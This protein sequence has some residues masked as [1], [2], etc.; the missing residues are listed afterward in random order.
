VT[1]TVWGAGAVGLVLGGR[2][3]RA[4]EDVFFVCRR[5]ESAEAIRAAGVRIEDLAS[6]ESFVVGAQAQPAERVRPEQLAGG[7]VLLCTRGPELEEA[8][9]AIQR[10]GYTGPVA[11]VTNGIDPEAAAAARFETVAG[12]VY[13]Q[14]CT[15]VAA[16]SAV[17]V[18]A[19]RV[20]VGAYPDGAAD[21]PVLDLAAQFARAGYDVGVSSRLSADRWLKLCVNLMSGPNALIRREDHTDP[22]FV[23]IKVRLLEEAR[24][25]LE[26]AGLH[27]CSCDERDRSLDEEIAFQR[28]AL[29][30]GNSARTLPL[31]NQVWSALR[32]G[33]TLEAD[34]YH[35]TILRLAA[36]YGLRAPMNE[37]VLEV[38]LQ[39]VEDRGGPERESATG[40]L[41]G[42]E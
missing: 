4:G 27:A 8:C 7:P 10:A 28:D 40:L 26:A 15:R 31:Y 37:R 16:H 23:A 1:T 30:S 39:A 22:A 13:R 29:E 34:A 18:G 41:E 33:S 38:L 32:D 19:G 9:R 42:I 24:S 25:V 12:V 14:T 21:G 2:L 35:R 36:E 11:C 5:P 20:I 17:T 3:V 6:G